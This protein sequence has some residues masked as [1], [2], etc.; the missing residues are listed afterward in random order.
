L[1]HDAM[2]WKKQIEVIDIYR[3]DTDFMLPIWKGDE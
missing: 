1:Y 2:R 3:K